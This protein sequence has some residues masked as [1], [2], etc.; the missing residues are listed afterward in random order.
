M[1]GSGFGRRN[2][3]GTRGQSTR[4]PKGSLSKGGMRG[5]YYRIGSGA[6]A[7]KTSRNELVLV[8][9]L[10]SPPSPLFSPAVVMEGSVRKDGQA[11]G[12]LGG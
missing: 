12:T 7:R 8:I 11:I 2:E 4:L 3:F 9:R 5:R 10:P 6:R 1:I